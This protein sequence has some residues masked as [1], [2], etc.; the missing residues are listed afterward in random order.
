MDL[1]AKS[2]RH[3]SRYL[4]GIIWQAIQ[5]ESTDLRNM[6]NSEKHGG[7]LLDDTRRP[8]KRHKG[9]YDSNELGCTLC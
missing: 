6:D 5:L 4:S 9:D 1:Y 7:L 2:V 8:T 3:L